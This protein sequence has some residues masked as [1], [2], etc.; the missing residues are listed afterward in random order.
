MN[1]RDQILAALVGGSLTALLQYAHLIL[2]A[3]GVQHGF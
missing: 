1:A 3:L 2:H